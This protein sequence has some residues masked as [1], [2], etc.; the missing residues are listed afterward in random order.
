MVIFDL[1]RYCY[2]DS[3][4]IP[5]EDDNVII[6]YKELRFDVKIVKD[7][8]C[9]ECAMRNIRDELG[10]DISCTNTMCCKLSFS[11]KGNATVLSNRYILDKSISTRVIRKNI[12][13]PDVC[14]FWDEVCNAYA[15]PIEKKDNCIF[16]I[17]VKDLI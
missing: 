10:I 4:Y 8:S 12:C 16:R 9:R 15:L 5:K 3:N 2:N 14:V 17:I 11:Y 7:G 6:K 13:N 1:E